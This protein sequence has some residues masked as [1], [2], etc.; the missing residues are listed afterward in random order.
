MMQMVR[1]DPPGGFE[2]PP[3][4]C[5]GGYEITWRFDGAPPVLMQFPLGETGGG[6]DPASL[7]IPSAIEVRGDNTTVYIYAGFFS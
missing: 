3:A 6:V 5:D 7:L 1:A 4:S 2:L